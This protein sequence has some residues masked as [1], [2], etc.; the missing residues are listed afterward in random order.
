MSL[1]IIAPTRLLPSLHL[2]DGPSPAGVGLHPRVSAWTGPREAA[3]RRRSVPDGHTCPGQK[4][5][6]GADRLSGPGMTEE[7]RRSPHVP[8]TAQ[9]ACGGPAR[10]KTNEET[11]TLIPLSSCLVLHHFLPLP[12]ELANT[13]TTAAQRE[14]HQSGGIKEQNFC[15]HCEIFLIVCLAR[16]VIH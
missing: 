14:T 11:H 1:L 16:V 5:R 4:N 7:P 12:S 6:S 9:T 3:G 2:S 13:A 8:P 10:W 15:R